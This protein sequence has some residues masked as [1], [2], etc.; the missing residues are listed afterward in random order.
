MYDFTNRVRLLY[1]KSFPN[2]GMWYN[3]AYQKPLATTK[4]NFTLWR[5][6][7]PKISAKFSSVILFPMLS[8]PSIRI[9]SLEY[10]ATW[11]R[12][13]KS[14]CKVSLFAC[15]S[16]IHKSRRQSLRSLRDSTSKKNKK[17][18]MTQNRIQ[19][20]AVIIKMIH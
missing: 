11:S 8:V 19:T 9:I 5:M 4:T 7:G 15:G 1:L 12:K 20:E 3:L 6:L 18:L 10:M 13:H 17:I 2:V 16:N 14:C